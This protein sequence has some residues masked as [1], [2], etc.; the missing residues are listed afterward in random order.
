[1][2][3]LDA[4]ISPFTFARL[5]RQGF[6]AVPDPRIDRTKLHP[7]PDLLMIALCTILCGGDGYEHM[8]EW[9]KM[10]GE[11]WLRERLGL[12]LPHGIPHHDTF[13][14]VLSRLEPG[15]L[16]GCLL[17]LARHCQERLRGTVVSL[18]GK[19]LRH[20]FAA[21]TGDDSLLLLNAWANDLHLVL[22]QEPVPL[23]GNEIS[24]VERLLAKLEVS[25]ATVTADALHCQKEMARQLRAKGADYLLCLKENHPTFYE[26]VSGLFAQASSRAAGSGR[27]RLPVDSHEETDGSDH[28]R[29]EVRR[30]H[31]LDA[32]LWLPEGDPLWQWEGLRS[33]VLVERYR[34]WTER[35]QSMETQ[36][37]SFYISSREPSAATLL[38]LVRSRWGI[39]NRLHHVLDVTFGEDASRV[40]RD[41]G[42]R[43]LAL[44]RRLA[45]SIARH[46]PAPGKSVRLRRKMAGWS[47]DF[48]LACLASWPLPAVAPS[49][50]LPAAPLC[51]RATRAKGGGRSEDGV[52]D[53]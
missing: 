7:L 30:C 22:A 43:N 14:R 12:A 40:R 28:G 29:V 11:A 37:H 51:A 46:A 13:R 47:G 33:L 41:H 1:M 38:A 53:R 15:A 4:P 5:L 3:S 10:Q 52:V 32:L 26:A 25:G 17:L 49:S 24:A 39:E 36:S 31:A 23:G 27:L 9:A 21:E 16:E 2:D 45:L 44:L 20:S 48:L 34:A 42:P 8:P 18:D 50:R 6:A 19:E 35:G